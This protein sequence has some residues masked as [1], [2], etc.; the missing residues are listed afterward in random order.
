[1]G[2]ENVT[3][4]GER[5]ESW[6][7]GAGTQDVVTTR[8]VAP[9]NVIV[10]YAAPLLREGGTLVAWK[11]RRDGAQEADGAA[12][13]ALTGLEPAGVLA[14]H[15][16]DGAEHLHLHRYA[17]VGPTPNRFPRRPGMATKRPLRAAG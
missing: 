12:A 1:M 11:G 8:A 13:G 15:P 16:W 9:L 7:A 4:V 14:V 10:E 6:R 2:L 3:V 17:K 5:A